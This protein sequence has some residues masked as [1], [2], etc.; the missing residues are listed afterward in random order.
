MHSDFHI[1]AHLSL[2]KKRKKHRN[3]QGYQMYHQGLNVL[4]LVGKSYMFVLYIKGTVALKLRTTEQVSPTIIGY[5]IPVR[6]Y[7]MH[8]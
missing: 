5:K 2:L 4:W 1:L 7:M 3:S 8:K 6:L